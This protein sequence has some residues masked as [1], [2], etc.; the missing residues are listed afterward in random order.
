MADL[1]AFPP[2]ATADDAGPSLASRWRVKAASAWKAA[3]KLARY[4]SLYGPRRTWAKVRA[5]RH[6]TRRFGTL[7]PSTQPVD[8]QQTVALIGCGNYAHCTL[9]YYLRRSQGNVIAGA[10]DTDPHRAASLAADH[11][12]PLHT[13]DANV[14]LSL[15]GL[16]LAVIPSNHASHAGYAIAAMRR[17]LD[18]YIEKPHVTTHAQLADLLDTFDQT[19]RRVYLGFNR[20]GSRLGRAAIRHLAAESGPMMLSW[21]IAGHEIAADHWYR[22][23]GEGGRVLGNLCHWSDFCLR[24]VGP[25]AFPVVVTPC[26]GAEPDINCTVTLQFADGSMGSLVFSEK[27][28]PIDG[29]R[30]TLVAQRGGTLLRLEDFDR[31]VVDRGPSRTVVK[32]WRRDHGHRTNIERAYCTTHQ[33][34]PYDRTEARRHLRQTALLFLAIRDSLAENCVL[35]VA[36]ELPA[37]MKRAA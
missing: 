23:P 1:L 35:T 19:G 18:A 14:L 30:E 34:L 33:H 31:L 7:P 26:R 15:D 3:R 8:P 21:F 5:K 17:G 11:H 24:A 9:G 6:L 16:R 13:D 12:A 4:Q 22:N 25:E 29:V 20:P 36:D 32:P 10:M 2:P 28:S 27:K 37:T